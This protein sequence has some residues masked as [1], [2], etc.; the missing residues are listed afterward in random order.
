MPCLG[1]A[2]ISASL[3]I[4]LTFFLKDKLYNKATGCKNSLFKSFSDQLYSKLIVVEFQSKVDNK[5]D[6][7]FEHFALRLRFLNLYSMF[8][9]QVMG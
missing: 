6:A 5:V 1:G 8:V 9:V 4:H 2:E 3:T 7:Q